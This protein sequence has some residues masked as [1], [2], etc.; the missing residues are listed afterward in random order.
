MVCSEKIDNIMPREKI[1]ASGVESLNDSE[2]ISV[3]LGCGVHGKSVF[4]LASE[5][6]LLLKEC[7]NFPRLED[8]AKISGLGRAKACQVLACLELSSRFLL[9]GQSQVVTNPTELLPRLSFLKR[10][11]QEQ[12]V[13]VSL[14]GGN[15]VIGVHALTIGLVNQTQIHPREA[16]A[17]A[18]RENAVS[19]LF[20]H[21]HPSGNTQPSREDLETTSRLVASG[22]ILDIPVLD[23]LIISS[24]GWVSLKSTHPNLF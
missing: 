23:H 10:A 17:L 24:E 2:L 15:R 13:C 6:S 14:N 9:G 21:N 5:L 3:I 20:A 12:M 4:S 11:P 22:R 19:V 8:L 18:I 16:F 1:L 7:T